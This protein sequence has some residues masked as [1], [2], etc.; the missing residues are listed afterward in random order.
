[1]R[2]SARSQNRRIADEIAYGLPLTLIAL[3]V[4][5]QCCSRFDFCCRGCT[6][7]ESSG[8]PSQLATRRIVV[9]LVVVVAG[10]VREEIQRAFLLRRFEVWLGG[11]TVGIIVTS[12]AFGAGHVL[13]GYDAA[14]V[15]GLL[16][17]SGLSFTCGGDRQ[18]PQWS[19][20]QRSTCCR[21][22]GSLS[23]DSGHITVGSGFAS[24]PPKADPHPDPPHTNR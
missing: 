18:W 16:G 22:P 20:M 5:I 7:A 12:V 13:Q 19:A 14:I 8:R 1:M 15:T 9:R 21:S 10:G 4:G 11:S 24:C 2:E 3:S 6:W 17:R 23:A